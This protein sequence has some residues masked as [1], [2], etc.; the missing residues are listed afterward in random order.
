MY[1]PQCQG[2]FHSLD[3]LGHSFRLLCRHRS[4]THSDKLRPGGPRL[5]GRVHTH[6]HISSR[7]PATL[8]RGLPAQFV[9]PSELGLYSFILAL[10][11]LARFSPTLLYRIY[12]ST[13]SPDRGPSIT[14]RGVVVV[15]SG[16]RSRVVSVQAGARWSSRSKA[17]SVSARNRLLGAHACRTCELQLV[18]VPDSRTGSSLRTQQMCSARRHLHVGEDI[19]SADGW[20][21]SV[22]IVVGVRSVRADL[23]RG[24]PVD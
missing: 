18:G 5:I 16:V 10:V 14:S 4:C 21:A 3:L 7:R 6:T 13:Y 24:V 15:L 20:V 17:A 12:Q 9:V 19:F 23:C 11:L 1:V 8:Q 2:G 22:H